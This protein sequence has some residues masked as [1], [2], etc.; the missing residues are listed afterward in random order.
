MKKITDNDK[1]MGIFS[2]EEEKMYRRIVTKVKAFYITM[3]IC[4]ILTV[5]VQECTHKEV[6]P[7]KSTLGEPTHRP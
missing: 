5:I 4:G 2:P 6:T 7:S 1:D 3:L